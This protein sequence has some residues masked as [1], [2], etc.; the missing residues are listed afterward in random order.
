MRVSARWADESTEPLPDD[1]QTW[2]D[3]VDAGIREWNQPPAFE[4]TDAKIL[5]TFD[6]GGGDSNQRHWAPDATEER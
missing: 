4:A 2:V 1:V 6:G 3:E 5:L